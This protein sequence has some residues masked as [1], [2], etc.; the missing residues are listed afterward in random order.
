VVDG[1]AVYR[2]HRV[3]GDDPT[4][5]E[6]AEEAGQGRQPPADSGRVQALHFA[7]MAFTGNDRLTI[8]SPELLPRG[9]AQGPQEGLDILRIPAAVSGLFRLASQTAL[10]GGQG[11]A[12]QMQGHRVAWKGKDGSRHEAQRNGNS[13]QV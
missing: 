5:D 2:V 7:Q 4:L 3:G 1:G 11:F 13:L 8:D 12:R 6:V 9:D 10:D